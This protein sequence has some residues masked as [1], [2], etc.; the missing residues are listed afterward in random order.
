MHAVSARYYPVCCAL[1]VF[2]YVHSL[3]Y[4]LSKRHSFFTFGFAGGAWRSNEAKLVDM[5]TPAKAPPAK[6]IFSCLRLLAVYD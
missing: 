6:P 3:L 2:V 4:E 1:I 5:V